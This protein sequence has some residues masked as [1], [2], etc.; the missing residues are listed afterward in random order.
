MPDKSREEANSFSQ[1]PRGDIL[2]RIARLF[3]V[4]STPSPLFAAVSER[5]ERPNAREELRRLTAH[6]VKWIE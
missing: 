4:N 1:P 3:T 5:L 6:E 2:E